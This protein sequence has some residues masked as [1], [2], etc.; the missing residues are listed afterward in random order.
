MTAKR[1]TGIV[2]RGGSIMAKWCLAHHKESFLYT[3]FEEICEIM[4]QYDVA[5][6]WAMACARARSPTP[7]TRRSSPSWK[8][9][10]S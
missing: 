2:S 8:R 6:R 4:K 9:W 1:V 3:H 7:M 5:S 10:A